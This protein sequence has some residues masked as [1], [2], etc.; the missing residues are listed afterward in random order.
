MKPWC[1]EEE[2]PT[3]ANLN[4]YRGWRSCVG[5]HRDYEPLFGECGEAELIVSVSFGCT[6]VFRWRCQS[7]PDDVRGSYSAR[8]PRSS[9]ARVYRVFVLHIVEE[10]AESQEDEQD[11]WREEGQQEE[12]G[13][14]AE[15]QTHNMS[16]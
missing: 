6:A 11:F 8:V 12:E 14:V 1:A 13:S 15:N 9:L 3:A 2:V 4:L 7:C 5:W 10:E 16:A